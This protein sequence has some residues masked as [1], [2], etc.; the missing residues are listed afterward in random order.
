[1]KS[2]SDFY[3]HYKET[4]S[5]Q[6]EY[7]SERNKLTVTLL[8]LLALVAGFIYDPNMVNEKVNTYIASH[9]DHLAFELK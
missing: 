4:F 7:L 6:Q 3:N 1:M 5:L 2:E 8:V 9:V